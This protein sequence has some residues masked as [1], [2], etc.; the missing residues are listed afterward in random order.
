MILAKKTMKAISDA[1]LHDQGASFRKWQ[2]QVLPHIG[3]AYSEDQFPF[4]R[5]MGASLIGRDCDRE[6]WYGFRWSTL[7]KHEGR[8]LRLFNRG[9]LEEG[10]F[11]SMLLMIGCMVYQQDENGNQ[12]TITDAGG[13]FGGSGDGLIENCPDIENGQ[14]ILGEMKTHSDKYFKKLVKVG[15]KEAKP[16]HYVQMQVYMR[17]MGYPACL[18]MAVNK[19][20]D[21]IH[22]EIVNLDRII[23]DNHIIR[24]NN[25][26]FSNSPPKRINES[27]GFWK[28]RF[29]DHKETCHSDLPPYITC[30]SCIHSLA[31]QNGTWECRVG[32]LPKEL[33]KQEQFKA[34]DKYKRLF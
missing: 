33:N 2:K 5:H 31:T 32:S 9:H 21:D 24:A 25:L 34:C 22:L 27:P 11:I 16:E 7:T 17:K 6:I 14:T 13:H 15:V 29:C 18:Y 20:D 30:R 12:F 4:R 28:C 8:I 19:N 1:M 10:R 3:D 23:A 26:I